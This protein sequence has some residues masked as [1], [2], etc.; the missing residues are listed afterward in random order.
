M[1]ANTPINIED[2]Y[3]LGKIL[4]TCIRLKIFIV[5]Y[6]ILE[7]ANGDDKVLLAL[8]VRSQELVDKFENTTFLKLVKIESNDE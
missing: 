5:G 6:N 4:D 3:Q 7:V 8:L 1:S 2:V